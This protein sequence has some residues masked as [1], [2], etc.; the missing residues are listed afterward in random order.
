MIDESTASEYTSGWRWEDPRWREWT[1]EDPA[2]LLLEALRR[3]V[4]IRDKNVWAG[5]ALSA[6]P[7]M[8]VQ[9]LPPL[10]LTCHCTV[11]IG[12][13]LTETV[14]D[15]GPPASAVWLAG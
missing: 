4:D 5:R 14:N 11:G 7:V 13:P 15:T 12:L 8:L 3:A 9:V 2:K 1:G 10:V 6:R